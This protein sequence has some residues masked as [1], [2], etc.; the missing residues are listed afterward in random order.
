MSVRL[1]ESQSKTA[2]RC[3]LRMIFKTAFQ[4][5]FLMLTFFQI[6][7]KTDLRI[8]CKHVPRVLL[9]GMS[10]LFRIPRLF[11]ECLDSFRMHRIF[12][13]CLNFFQNA[14][15]FLRMTR[16]F[17][18]AQNFFKMPRLFLECLEFFRMPTLDCFSKYLNFFLE[19]MHF[20]QNNQNYFRMHRL[21]RM[22]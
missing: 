21:F 4:N 7:F 9:F 18:N 11:P 10:E 1:I 3:I 22:P 16:I 6:A 12:S 13:E 20:F 14:S 2:S 5:C 19:C 8:T 17:Q 15:T